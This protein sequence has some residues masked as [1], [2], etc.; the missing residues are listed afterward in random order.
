[1]P[2]PAQ[3]DLHVNVPLTNVSVA[4]IQS[5]S[6]YIANKVFPQVPV[7]KQSDLYWKYSKSDWRRTDVQRRAPGTESPGVGW[8]FDT[9][10]Y[11]CHVY[12]VHKDIDDQV[13]A[14]ADSNF[15]LDSDAT[16]FITNQLLLKRDLDW[17]NAY[18]KTGV[19]ST[20]R[21][22]VA[23]GPNSSQFV[24]WDQAG[25]DPIA[26]VAKYTIDFR[27]LTGFS[28]NTMVVGANTMRVLKNHPDILDRIKYTQKGVITE[29]LIAGLFGVQKLLVSYATSTAVAEINDADVQDAAATY[30]FIANSK[31]ALLCHTPSAPSLMTPA[32]G[33]TFTW[34]GY[35]AGNSQ[36]IRVKSFRQEHIASD[37]VEA[38]M[39]YDMKVIAPDMGVFLAAAVA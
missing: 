16:K 28:P 13:R 17:A 25:S 5:P 35:A 32:A 10:S 24:Q 11:F 31:A 22:G 1:M 23:S 6:E 39:T 33:Y 12:A 27:E 30:S 26:D 29:D 38:E 3:S 19:W 14:N 2:N 20:D 21:T 34:N 8:K 9:D 15:R 36:G 7:Q 4:Y 37:R 18:F